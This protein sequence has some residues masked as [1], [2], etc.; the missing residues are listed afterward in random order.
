MTWW[1]W[2]LIG[3][4]LLAFEVLTPGGL[5]A[6]FFGF[7]A[8]AV[9]ALSALLAVPTPLQWVLFAVLSA[10]A[11]GLLRRRLAARLARRAV[12]PVD[13]IVGEVAVPL[14][15][16]APQ[17]TGHA[18]L[19]GTSWQARNVGATPLAAGQ[20]CKVARLDGLVLELTSG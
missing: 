15:P 17:A 6:L 1:H 19:R 16:L 20:R 13:A 4:A 14:E 12:A 2:T 3:L 11:V 7:G 18:E 8:L 5:V 9:A 10:V